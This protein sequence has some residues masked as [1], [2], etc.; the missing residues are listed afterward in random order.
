[1]KLSFTLEGPS[2]TVGF[3]DVFISKTLLEDPNVLEVY[4]NTTKLSPE[5]YIVCSMGNS[6]RSHLEIT[7][8][9]KYDVSIIIPEFASTICIIVFLI[10]TSTTV[11][12]CKRLRKAKY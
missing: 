12:L 7:F 8:A 1:M 10:F 11:V 6:W 5:K 2:E 9:S 4:L 3:V